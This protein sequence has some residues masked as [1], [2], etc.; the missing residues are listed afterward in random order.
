MVFLLSCLFRLLLWTLLTSDLS[1]V[2]LAIGVG[3]SLLLPHARGPKQPLAPTLRALWR[4]LIAVPLAYGEAFALIGSGD[5]EEE[6]WIERPAGDPRHR[7]LIFLEVLAITLT[8]FTI[9]L[10]LSNGERGPHYTI[11]QLRPRRG[12]PEEV[13]P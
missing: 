13:Q 12:K 8:P 5:R 2:N 7:L 9:V 11:H 10:G 1:A 3:L 4:S 6:S